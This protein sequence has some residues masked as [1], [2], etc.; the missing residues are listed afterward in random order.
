MSL[1]PLDDPVEKLEKSEE[2]AKLENPESVQKETVCVATG[3]IVQSSI[4][5]TD[6]TKAGDE[7]PMPREGA[8]ITADE[9]DKYVDVVGCSTPVH[10]HV[11]SERF[12][13]G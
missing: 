8:A 2:E 9:A 1:N 11:E 6:S 12:T 3:L 10:G 4:N 5:C 7:R 13:L